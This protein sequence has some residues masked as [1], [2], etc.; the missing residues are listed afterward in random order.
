VSRYLYTLIEMSFSKEYGHVI[1]PFIQQFK[2][3]KNKKE[4]KQVIGDAVEAVKKDWEMDEEKRTVLPKDLEVVR[5]IIFFIPQ[6]FSPMFITSG[7][8]QIH[9][10]ANKEG[11]KT[12][13]GQRL[14]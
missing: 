6:S 10:R 12:T 5:L 11:R 8:K 7:C 2:D 3:G 13:S 9:Y 4:R 1:L 14:L